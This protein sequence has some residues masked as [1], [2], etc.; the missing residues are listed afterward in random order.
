MGGGKGQKSQTPPHTP[1][2]QN[3]R[4][5]KPSRREWCVCGVVCVSNKEENKVCLS[6]HI[7]G[8]KITT[9]EILHF[10]YHTL[11]SWR[12][13]SKKCRNILAVSQKYL[14]FTRASWILLGYFSPLPRHFTPEN[15]HWIIYP[16]H[17]CHASSLTCREE[18]TWW[19]RIHCILSWKSG[20]KT[21][22]E[23]SVLIG[24]SHAIQIGRNLLQIS[25]FP[26]ALIVREK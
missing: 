7:S 17:H 21:S 11:L 25:H 20:S 4:E 8:Q 10:N 3:T 9:D 19:T 24:Y 14:T 18:T 15:P 16:Q 22:A 13:A 26:P 2:P 12:K 6:K 5:K 23:C 1:S